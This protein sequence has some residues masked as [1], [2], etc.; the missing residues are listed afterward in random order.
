MHKNVIAGVTAGVGVL[1]AASVTGCQDGA[2]STVTTPSATV[3]GTRTAEAAVP[4]A[5]APAATTDDGSEQTR[6]RASHD[7]H[8][9]P[10]DLIWRLPKDPSTWTKLPKKQDGLQQWFVKPGCYV[11]LW[12]LDG[13]GGAHPMTNRDVLEKIA[14]DNSSL[15]PGH[16]KPAYRSRTTTKLNAFVAGLSD[17][18]HVT[19][20]DSTVDYGKARARIIAYR[21]GDLALAYTGYCRTAADFTK[22]ATS[23]FDPWL[24]DLA[25]ESTY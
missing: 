11:R 13:A 24:Q 19:M 8:K 10:I 14:V 23:D 21:D 2:S 9:A 4:T 1:L 16:P 22:V 18:G 20:A 6:V 3:A 5:S 7:A 12:Q 15:F 25:E 17:V